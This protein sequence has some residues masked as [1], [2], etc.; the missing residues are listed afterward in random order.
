MT[1]SA[2]SGVDKKIAPATSR[3]PAK[4][5]IYFTVL[6][7]RPAKLKY[8]NTAPKISE[9]IITQKPINITSFYLNLVNETSVSF[10]ESAIY[11]ININTAL[12]YWIY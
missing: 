7:N 4:K 9:R 2:P 1:K 6:E 8:I 12:Y 5:V 11:M 3:N 10:Y